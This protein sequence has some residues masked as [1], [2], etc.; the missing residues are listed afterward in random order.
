[1]PQAAW[2]ADLIAAIPTSIAVWASDAEIRSIESL[3]G[4]LVQ[5]DRRVVVRR[6]NIDQLTS[7]QL[8]GHV[9]DV[10][11]QEFM[12]ANDKV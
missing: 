6:S 3:C 7:H 5:V 1:M 10:T 4:V 9:S 12:L 8:V 11:H 2:I